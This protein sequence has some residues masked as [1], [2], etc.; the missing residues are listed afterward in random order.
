MASSAARSFFL[1][2]SLL[3]GKARDLVHAVAAAVF[4]QN[5]TAPTGHDAD[6]DHHDDRTC[7]KAFDI[8]RSIVGAHDL[9][10]NDAADGVEDVYLIRNAR[11]EVSWYSQDVPETK[12]FLVR[13]A[14]LMDQSGHIRKMEQAS[15]GANRKR[16]YTVH[17]SMVLGARPVN[18]KARKDMRVPKMARG[19]RVSV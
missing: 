5:V 7:G 15:E 10:T 19:K 13:P 3:R 16:P 14:T 6:V 4:P 9:G 11:P 8:P 12:D 18:M 2:L 17:L 1:Q